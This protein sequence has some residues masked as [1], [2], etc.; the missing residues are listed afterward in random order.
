MTEPT[1]PDV[2]GEMSTFHEQNGIYAEGIHVDTATLPA[3]RAT[4]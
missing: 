2:T 3:D 4:D 1:G